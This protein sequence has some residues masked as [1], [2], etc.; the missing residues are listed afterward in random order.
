VSGR[1]RTRIV[2]GLAVV[3]TSIAAIA[4][5]PGA[6]QAQAQAA[7]RATAGTTTGTSARGLH[8]EVAGR[9][10]PVVLIHAFQTDLREWNEI[11]PALART[12]R[13]IRYDV[14]GHGQSAGAD[15]SYSNADDLL[16][17]LRGLGVA[18]ADLVGLSMGS[19]IA[20]E[21][22][23]AHPE[24]ARRIVMISPGVPGIGRADM[25]PWMTPII[26]AVQAR[27]TARAAELWWQ[28]PYFA[29][30]RERGR[31]GEAYHVVVRDNGKVWT[32]N[33]S[34]QRRPDPPAGRRLGEVKAPMLVIV[35][36]LDG[37]ASR[38]HGDTLVAH[39][40]GARLVT[41]PGAGHMVSL[42]APAEVVKAITPFLAAK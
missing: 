27:D 5:G 41:I 14:R 37:S 1:A 36:A 23:L 9:G 35:G 34:V 28:S 40:R 30:V 4:A 39:V 11:A 16:D 22:A 12:H 8:Y 17:L 21:L 32:G 15:S 25:L 6:A 20:L 18:R 33:P 10:D 42:A 26:A 31:A 13:V 19:T 3:A 29:G 24:M 38:A 7:G 2:R